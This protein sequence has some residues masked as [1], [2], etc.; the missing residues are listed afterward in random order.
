MKPSETVTN[1]KMWKKQPIGRQP[2][3][4]SDSNSSHT[5]MERGCIKLRANVRHYINLFCISADSDSNSK[6]NADSSTSKTELRKK[7]KHRRR[8]ITICTANCRYEVV[9]RVA[10]RMGMREVPE[11]ESWNLFWTDLSISVERCKEMK[12]FQVSVK[13]ESVHLPFGGNKIKRVPN[14]TFQ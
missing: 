7:R 11:D 14:M 2:F 5:V 1:M 3:C 6:Y 8:P 12:R 4:H 13:T 9:R 10:Y